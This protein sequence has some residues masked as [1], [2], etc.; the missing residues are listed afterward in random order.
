M[1]R[2]SNLRSSQPYRSSNFLH[3]HHNSQN[4]Q[5]QHQHHAAQRQTTRTAFFFFYWDTQDKTKKN[6]PDSTEQVNILIQTFFQQNEY[7]DLMSWDVLL[8]D[9]MVFVQDN[10]ASDVMPESD[11]YEWLKC[12]ASKIAEPHVSWSQLHQNLEDH[13]LTSAAIPNLIAHIQTVAYHPVETRSSWTLNT[14]WS[15]NPFLV[16]F[17]HSQNVG[18]WEINLPLQLDKAELPGQRDLEIVLQKIKDETFPSLQMY[19]SI[20]INTSL[21]KVVLTWGSASQHVNIQTVNLA[22]RLYTGM[23]LWVDDMKQTKQVAS[24]HAILWHQFGQWEQCGTLKT[25]KELWEAM[26]R[27][28]QMSPPESPWRPIKPAFRKTTE[29]NESPTKAPRRKF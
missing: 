25:N 8:R 20:S 24:P 22:K 15:S 6:F 28:E 21:N 17:Q 18:P 12:A 14:A 7:D 4:S 26:K 2:V 10:L 11:D 3:G 23:L 27:L 29:L 1:K 19:F 13:W 9:L 16:E 5:D